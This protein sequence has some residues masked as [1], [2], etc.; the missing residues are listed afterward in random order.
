[1]VR[2]LEIRAPLLFRIESKLFRSL[3]DEVLHLYKCSQFAAECAS[4]RSAAR[5]VCQLRF[6]AAEVG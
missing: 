5:L 6:D 2:D 4:A 1:M 3:A